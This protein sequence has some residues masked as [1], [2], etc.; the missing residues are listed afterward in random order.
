MATLQTLGAILWVLEWYTLL[1]LIAVIA[2]IIF[3]VMY[4]RR[5]M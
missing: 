1:M 3:L 4:R 5:Q 2:L